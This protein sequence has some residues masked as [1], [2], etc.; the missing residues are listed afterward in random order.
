MLP[1]YDPADRQ[2]RAVHTDQIHR[3]AIAARVDW[4]RQLDAYRRLR[5]G[6]G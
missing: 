3:R 2:R 5:A 6:R 1:W 4:E